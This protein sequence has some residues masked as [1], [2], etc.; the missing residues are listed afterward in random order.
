M[1]KLALA[2]AAAAMVGLFAGSAS[3]APANKFAVVA[4]T[5]DFMWCDGTSLGGSISC[6][7]M[8]DNDGATGGTLVPGALDDMATILQVAY[9]V[10]TS[11]DLVIDINLEC[12][13]FNEVKSTKNGTTETSTSAA[14]LLVFLV[15]DDD[16]TV[17]DGS[18]PTPAQFIGVKSTDTSVTQAD[19]QGVIPTCIDQNPC[20]HLRCPMDM[21]VH[22]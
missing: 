5:T 13:L 2:A 22:G 10:S 3:A 1:R 15:V 8:I 7:S 16:N 21:I 9:K 18:D 12:M 11:G 19:I 4:S 17:V 20:A 6:A 14:G